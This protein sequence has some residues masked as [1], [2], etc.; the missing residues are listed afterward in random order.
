MRQGHTETQPV[1]REVL[2]CMRELLAPIPGLTRRYSSQVILMA[3]LTHAG[4]GLRKLLASGECSRE[5]VE[6]WCKE[7][8]ALAL[9]RPR[10]R[11]RINRRMSP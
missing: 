5:D 2:E 8:Q 6:R 11:V 9:K 10:H 4:A 1:P 7:L 3:L